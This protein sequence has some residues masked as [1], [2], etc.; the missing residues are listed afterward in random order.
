MNDKKRGVADE[1]E[2][3]A[4]GNRDLPVAP[5]FEN[6]SS[7]RSILARLKAACCSRDIP[8]LQVCDKNSRRK[9]R[10]ID[11]AILVLNDLPGVIGGLQDPVVV[12][13]RIACGKPCRA[14]SN[15]SWSSARRSG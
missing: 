8:M 9:M 13:P 14:S 4:T 11:W 6:Q 10:S 7:L 12:A 15:A 1:G 3:Q 2:E 5:A